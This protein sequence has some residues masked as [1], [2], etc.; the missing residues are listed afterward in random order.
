MSLGWVQTQWKVQQPPAK[1]R[2][3][4]STPGASSVL[5]AVQWELWG[6]VCPL[7]SLISPTLLAAGPVFFLSESPS[8]D[9]V[10][11]RNTVLGGVWVEGQEVKVTLN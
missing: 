6:E 4:S 1:S 11:G 9:V 10:R 3:S 7:G 5:T 2:S 8:P